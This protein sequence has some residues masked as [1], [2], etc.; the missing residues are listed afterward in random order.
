[1]H[2]SKLVVCV[3]GLLFFDIIIDGQN[4]TQVCGGDKIRYG[5]E[6][7]PNSIYDW[8][9]PGATILKNYNDSI[10]IEWDQTNG[11]HQIEVTEHSFWGCKTNPIVG[12]VMVNVLPKSLNKN[13]YLCEGEEYKLETKNG[14]ES[15]TWSTGS[16]QPF[17]EINDPGY[18]WV[19]V[20]SSGCK[21]RDSTLATMNPK[22]HFTLGND[23]ELCDGKTHT[24]DPGIIAAS[25]QWSNGQQSPTIDI[26]ETGTFWAKL[27]NFEGC[28]STDTII[29]KPCRESYTDKIPNVFTPNGDNDND[30]WRIDFL[31]GHEAEV[32]IYNRWG[33]MVYH[34]K[35]Y[36]S[37]G[38]DGTSNGVPL[39]VDVYYYII[40]LDN[41]SRPLMGSVT[42]VK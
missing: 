10:D 29:V 39:P 36:P 42:I 40:K 21:T 27:T 35:N 11:I 26:R 17:I 18:Y 37:T 1:M 30:T 3:L 4:L 8:N 24:I 12:Y 38:W 7:H 22:P 13:T 41:I 15:V 2:W 9:I 23:I 20:T 5:I 34:S 28:S 19:D 25:Y 31:M 14:F 32:T 6:G 33:Q 16:H